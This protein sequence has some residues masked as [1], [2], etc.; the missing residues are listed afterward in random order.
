MLYII[1][2]STNTQMMFVDVDAAFVLHRIW[3]DLGG[4]SHICPLASF[5]VCSQQPCQRW[6]LAA[7]PCSAES[8]YRLWPQLEP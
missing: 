2:P 8:T 3:I 7:D 4:L 6:G 5:Q 1:D